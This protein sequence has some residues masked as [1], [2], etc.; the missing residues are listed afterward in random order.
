VLVLLSGCASRYAIKTYPE[1]AKVAVQNVI[2]KEVFE[3]GESPVDFEHLSKFGEGFVIKV[4]KEAFEP[5]EFFV[6]RQPGAK[7]EFQVNLKPVP[8]EEGAKSPDEKKNEEEMKERLALLERTFEIYKDALFSQRYGSSPASYD[9]RKI[10]LSVGLISKA[11]QLIEQRKIDEANKVLDSILEKD[12][13]LVQAH[14]LKGTAAYLSNDFP[15]AVRSWERA[16]E[17]NPYEKLTRQ[18]LVSAYEKM[19]LPN[20]GNAEELDVIDRIPAASPLAPDP[21]NLRLKNR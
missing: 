21:L 8:Q 10:D 6:A 16:L 1:G 19:G 11:Q 7:A 5:K 20:P 17:I 14:V 4:E 15:A 3:V 12:A 9:R 2:S 18:Y 13:Y